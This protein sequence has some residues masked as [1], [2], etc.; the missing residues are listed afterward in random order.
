MLPLSTAQLI[1]TGWDAWVN[2]IP[3]AGNLPGEELNY[4][5]Q[6]IERAE[7]LKGGGVKEAEAV[8][9]QESG[10]T[11]KS[12]AEQEGDHKGRG[13]KIRLKG[14]RKDGG[15]LQEIMVTEGREAKEEEGQGARGTTQLTGKVEVWKEGGIEGDKPDKGKT[16][17]PWHQPTLTKKSYTARNILDPQGKKKPSENTSIPFGE[18]ELRKGIWQWTRASCQKYQYRWGLVIREPSCIKKNLP[19]IK[20]VDFVPHV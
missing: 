3:A 13:S 11:E 15:L 8:E 18:L 4:W 9:R 7:P 2:E 5:Y 6:S 17:S 14:R 19:V 20:P 16:A 10:E 12:K 1:S